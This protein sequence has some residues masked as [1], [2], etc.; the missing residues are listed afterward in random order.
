MSRFCVPPRFFPSKVPACRRSWVWAKRATRSK[1]L[2]F[3]SHDGLADLYGIPSEV[4]LVQL[5][6]EHFVLNELLLSPNVEISLGRL[7][8]AQGSPSL[9][10]IT[11]P[12]THWEALP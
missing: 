3:A 6:L 10:T 1:P 12:F 8:S 2:P 11:F 5:V 9:M 4:A 7:P